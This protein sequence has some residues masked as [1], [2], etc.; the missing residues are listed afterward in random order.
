MVSKSNEY[1]LNNIANHPSIPSCC[2]P[3]RQ[4]YSWVCYWGSSTIINEQ[5][6]TYQSTSIMKRTSTTMNHEQVFIICMLKPPI[7]FDDKSPERPSNFNAHL[8]HGPP[9][10]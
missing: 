2:F 1:I 6:I 4:L 8:P 7:Q 5:H 10:L 3:Q 9:D